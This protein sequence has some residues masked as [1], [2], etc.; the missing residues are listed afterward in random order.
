MIARFFFFEWKR[1]LPAWLS[2]PVTY[3]FY[4]LWVVVLTGML[5]HYATLVRLLSWIPVAIR[6]TLIAAGNVWG[7]TAVASLGI[8]YA[9]RFLTR[10]LTVEHSPG[11]AG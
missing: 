4:A 3:V 11:V 1:R 8:Y 2:R 5:L 9:Y 7:M 6:S 10:N